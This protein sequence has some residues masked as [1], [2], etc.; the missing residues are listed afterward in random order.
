MSGGAGLFERTRE[1]L[2]RAVRGVTQAAR[3][4]W[5]G[6]FDPALPEA[7]RDRL[8]RRIAE[9]LAGRGGEVSARQRA[10][11]LAAIYGGLGAEGR[12]RFFDLLARRFGPDRAAIDAA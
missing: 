5:G 9:C 10:A 11:E 6:G 8:E 2:R 4:A 7:D 3:A 12:E 1:G